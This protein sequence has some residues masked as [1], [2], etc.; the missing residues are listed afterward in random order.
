[1]GPLPWQGLL[2]CIPWPGHYPKVFILGF[3]IVN[4]LRQAASDP[5]CLSSPFHGALSLDARA[6]INPFSLELLFSEYFIIAT[7]KETLW[8]RVNQS[9]LKHWNVTSVPGG[10]KIFAKALATA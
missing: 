1:M 10:C 9:C 3:L 5:F 8:Q 7:E 2:G 4:K 6:E